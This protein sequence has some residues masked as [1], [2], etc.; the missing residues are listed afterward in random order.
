MEE[1]LDIWWLNEESEQMLN[2]G[3][4]NFKRRNNEGAI[5]RQRQQ[6]AYTKPELILLLR[7]D[8]KG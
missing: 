5:D 7:N 6:N 1:K 2:R 4:S 3:I 8:Y